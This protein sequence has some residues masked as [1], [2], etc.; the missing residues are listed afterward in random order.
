MSAETDLA[1]RVEAAFKE[2]RKVLV[3]PVT[4]ALVL[5]GIVILLQTRGELKVKQKDGHV[6]VELH[7]EKKSTADSIVKKFF[8][9]FG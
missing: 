1:T 9:L 7:V 8:S 3:E 2:D 4:T 5:A 6:D